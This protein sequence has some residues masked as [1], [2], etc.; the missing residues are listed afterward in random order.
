VINEVHITISEY[1]A[2]EG[3]KISISLENIE[4]IEIY[5][6]AKGSTVASWAFSGL[7]I[8]SVLFFG[9][10]GIAVSGMSG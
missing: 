2:S 9:F 6:K 3:N 1:N 8:A 4:K 10:I 5:D 7:G